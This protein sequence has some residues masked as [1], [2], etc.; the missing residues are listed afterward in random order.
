MEKI[1]FITD[2][3]RTIIHA[4][5]KGF[6]CVEFIGDR[7][8]T[9]M[10]QESYLKLNTML[11]NKKINFIPCTMR[12]IEQTLRVDFIKKYSPKIIICTNGAQIF[13]DGKLDEV[14]NNKMKSLISFEQVE[15]NINFIKSFGLEYD[16]IRNIEGFYI[17]IKC[18]T[19]KEAN[20]NFE[21][22]NDKFE[23]N[24]NIL[25]IGIKIFIIDKNIDKVF[26]VK[27]VVDNYNMKNV[28][29]SGDS[30]V[31]YN[32]TTIGKSILPKHASFKHKNSYITE[33]EGIT[34]TE[35]I[36]TFLESKFVN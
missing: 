5:N 1:Y 11:E 6:R 9:Y 19:K 20:K 28:I 16:E 2:L 22:L 8:I 18:N 24:L 15:H 30:I 4:K 21:F 3:D 25:H 13:I 29:T 26:A 14:W 34:S 12:N 36:L 17:T 27:Y 32:F 10:T 33:K 31:D 23:N 35:D 7:E